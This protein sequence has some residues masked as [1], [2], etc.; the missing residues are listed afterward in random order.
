M[1]SL[2]FCL[3]IAYLTSSLKDLREVDKMVFKFELGK[4]FR[5]YE[6]L[7]GVLPVAS[8]EHVPRAY[9]VRLTQR[10]LVDILS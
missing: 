8:K 5:P 6:Q 3:F 4:P 7:M 10:L 9:Q 2:T 1:I